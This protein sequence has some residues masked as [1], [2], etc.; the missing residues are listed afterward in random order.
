MTPMSLLS[1]HQPKQGTVLWHV[2]CEA[3]IILNSFFADGQQ[4]AGDCGSQD[5]PQASLSPI[6]SPAS[7]HRMSS[8]SLSAAVAVQDDLQMAID[9]TC[10]LSQNDQLY[11]WLS[12]V[13]CLHSN[14]SEVYTQS[15]TTSPPR[16]AATTLYLFNHIWSKAPLLTISLGPHLRVRTS[17]AVRPGYLAAAIVSGRDKVAISFQ[18]NA[19]YVSFTNALLEAGACHTCDPV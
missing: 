11:P 17:T 19:S 15:R 12:V 7:S 10:E 1:P 4:P 6:S 13:G 18:S 8:S 3:Q 16:P 14:S 5:A 9:L 2:S